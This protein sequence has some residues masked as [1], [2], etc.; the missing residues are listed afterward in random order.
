[1]QGLWCRAGSPASRP[2]T[3]TSCHISGG[4]R[5]EIKGTIQYSPLG[6]PMDR[7]AWWATAHGGHKES[8]MA[9]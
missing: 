7:G 3:S 4:I 9:E 2:W 5:L 1:M 6:N 8:D